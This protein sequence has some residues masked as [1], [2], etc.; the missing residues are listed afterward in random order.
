MIV[1]PVISHLLHS[2]VRQALLDVIIILAVNFDELKEDL[3]VS[4]SP[5]LFE[6][7]ASFVHASDFFDSGWERLL[8]LVEDTTR[9]SGARS[10]ANFRDAHDRRHPGPLVNP[11]ALWLWRLLQVNI[12]YTM[13][14]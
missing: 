4:L 12:F 9:P 5:D 2:L 6:P 10:S 3:L 14:L 11:V 7:F 1:H 8:G 13:V